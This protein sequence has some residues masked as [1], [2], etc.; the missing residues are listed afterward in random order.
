VTRTRSFFEVNGFDSS[1][2]LEKSAQD[3]TVMALRKEWRISLRK[4]NCM[5]LSLLPDS[6]NR[7][8]E[9]KQCPDCFFSRAA[10]CIT[11]GY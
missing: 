6:R 3:I 7:T 11:K 2:C 8:R 10:W 1:F 9:R 5:V 4:F